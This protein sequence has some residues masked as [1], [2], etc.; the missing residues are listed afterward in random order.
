M[1]F[2]LWIMREAHF[3]VSERAD[4]PSV[5]VMRSRNCSVESSMAKGEGPFIAG[6]LIVPEI[7]CEEGPGVLIIG[8]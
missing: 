7:A 8:S 3:K 4:M 1:R 2:E 6:S 5:F